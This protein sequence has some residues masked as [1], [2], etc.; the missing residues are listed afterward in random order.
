MTK[1]NKSLLSALALVLV[2]AAWL[3]LQRTGAGGGTPAPV[4]DSQGPLELPAA[5]EG[6][7]IMT[8]QGYVSSYNPETLIPDWVAY[9]LTA[10]ETRG[11]ATRAEKDFSMDFNFNGKQARREDYFGIGRA[12]V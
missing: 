10:E 12:H 5:R 4:L 8:Y 2:F 7:R 3:I 9:E 1:Q 6:D 11:E